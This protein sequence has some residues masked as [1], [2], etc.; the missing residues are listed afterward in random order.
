MQSFD[1]ELP[2]LHF[3]AL[4]QDPILELFRCNLDSLISF[5]A[6]DL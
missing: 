3:R 1:L 4:E 5:E 6:N 2:T